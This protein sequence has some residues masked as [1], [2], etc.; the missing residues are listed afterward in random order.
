MGKVGARKMMMV[1]VLCLLMLKLVVCDFT[2][3]LV[4]TQLR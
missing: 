3:K 4:H 2:H 1:A